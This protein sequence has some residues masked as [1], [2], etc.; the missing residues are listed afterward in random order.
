[1]GA[2]ANFRVE[3][4]RD[5]HVLIRD[6]GPWT[7]HLSCTNDAEGVVRR[8]FTSRML[9]HGQRLFVIDSEGECDEYL[10]GENDEF[11]SFIV[12]AMPPL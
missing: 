8:L 10:I 1:M 5:T 11:K 7:K 2:P 6:M 9:S 3:A 4:V 12:G